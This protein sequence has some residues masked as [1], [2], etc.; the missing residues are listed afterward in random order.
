[1]SPGF[2]LARPGWLAACA[3]GLVAYGVWMRY[4]RPPGIETRS[5]LAGILYALLAGGG[6]AALGGWLA[7]IQTAAGQML[8]A[9]AAAVASIFAAAS[10]YRRTA[11]GAGGRYLLTGLRALAWFG[12]LILAARPAWEW[13]IAE[14]RKPRVEVV[15]DDSRS[16]SIVDDAGATPMPSPPSTGPATRPSRDRSRAPATAAAASRAAIA[17]AAFGKARAEIERVER[18]YDLRVRPLNAPADEAGRTPWRIDA[19]QPTTP[20]AAAVERAAGVVGS[21]AAKPFA[22][23]VVTDG[24]ETPGDEAAMRQASAALAREGIALWAVGVGPAE[25]ERR[26]VQ[27]A[28]LNLPARIGIHDRLSV[29]ISARVR[30]YEDAQGRVELFFAGQPAETRRTTIDGD[31]TT[32]VRTFEI[33][34]PAPGVQ[35]VTARIVL[36]DPR[37]G[38]TVYETHGLV[39]VTRGRT[40]VLMLEGA[41]RTETA[42]IT[43]ALVGDERFELTRLFFPREPGGLE[44][45]PSVPSETWASHDVVIFGSV[46]RWRITTRS[47]EAL[48]EAV[49]GQGLGLLLAGGSELLDNQRYAAS[50]LEE[51]SPAA[52]GSAVS[53][54]GWR[55]PFLPTEIGLRHPVLRL[56]DDPAADMRAWQ[57]LPPLSGAAQLGR[58]APLAQ[59]L[60]D[61]GAQR[62]LL[63]VHEVGA[64]RVAAAA[65]ESTWPWALASDEGHAL[66]Q[67]FW[68]QLT[69]WLA[70]RRPSAWVIAD[71][72][73]Y[74]LDALASGRAQV[75]IRA[76]VTGL[77]DADAAETARPDREPRTPGTRP[78]TSL[79]MRGPGGDERPVS[80]SSGQG[81]WSA[82]VRP[83][84][85][86]TYELQFSTTLPDG[87]SLEARTQ[88]DVAAIDLEFQPPTANLP[89]LRD[90]AEQTQAAGGRFVRIERFSEFLE[91]LASQDR[92]TRAERRQ[93]IDV[94]D[95]YRWGWLALVAGALV[96][97]WA[98]RKR[99]AL[100]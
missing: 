72:V 55:P 14:W 81:E 87:R 5:A 74:S 34:P 54:G 94:V 89:L 19:A 50:P 76:G 86:G 45:Q 71:R 62:P 31:L 47:L 78:A 43:R 41:P 21:G 3:A 39:E 77:E 99:N 37:G 42:F 7:Y 36:P 73:T 13:T 35:R 8:L 82:R 22:V 67:R 96:M 6:A 57:A 91:E 10:A 11:A 28:P 95:R 20:L 61:D 27:L 69:A 48:K 58:L 25:S 65:W 40:R 79:R 30:G 33:S 90:A 46:P 64:G 70:N 66:H 38:E 12:L 56:S 18:F 16:M 97:E 9:V 63:A 83:S 53:S 100:V 88:F 32:V 15:L 49:Q 44:S 2:Q 26:Q 24:A 84:Q 23:M 93:R 1:M 75:Q 17:N 85:A 98:V 92:R 80:L 51:I 60:A 68:R 4:R 52:F 59:V 29:Q